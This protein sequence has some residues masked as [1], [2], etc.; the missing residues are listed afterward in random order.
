[1]TRVTFILLIVLINS[2]MYQIVFA[3]NYAIKLDGVDDYLEVFDSPSLDLTNA[4]TITA[5]YYPEETLFYEPGLVQK[6]GPG[7]WGRYGVWI[8]A[9]QIDFCIT[10]TTSGQVCLYPSYVLT[11]NEWSHIAAVYN[12]S[13]MEI[14]VNG[15]SVD[16][17]VLSAPISVSDLN[18]YIGADPSDN[19]YLSGMLDELTIWNVARTQEQITAT[20]YDTL[21]A[22][23]YA[24]PDSGLVAYYRFDKYEDLNVNNDGED[25]I[26]DFSYFG[27]HA[28]S[29]G[30][31]ELVLISLLTSAEEYSNDLIPREF[32]LNQNYPNPFNPSTRIKF[33]L[34]EKSLVTLKVYNIVGEEVATLLNE[35]KDGG[36]HSVDFDAG[37]LSSG[38]YFYKIQAVPLGRQAGSYTSTKKM[39]LLK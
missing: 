8:Y 22:A 3:Q 15:N 5:W 35:E 38:V 4:I 37:R 24:T 21:S 39:L 12:G 27:N 23:Y 26:R 6:D 31:P 30:S 18:L 7:S 1:M 9:N 13:T 29:Y 2:L 19:V 14:F 11:E 20:M 32:S 34:P 28:D 33:S 25:D 36:I 10:P 17:R 16:S